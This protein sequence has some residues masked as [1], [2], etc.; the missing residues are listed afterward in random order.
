LDALLGIVN[1]IRDSRQK[2]HPC[3]KRQ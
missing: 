1:R 3:R 2:D